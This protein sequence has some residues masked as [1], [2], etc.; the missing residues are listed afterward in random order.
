M[1]NREKKEQTDETE[2]G[3]A[4]LDGGPQAMRY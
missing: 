1:A 4:F 2:N 3:G